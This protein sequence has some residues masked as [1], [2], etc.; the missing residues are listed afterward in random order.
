MN[1]DEAKSMFK[2]PSFARKEAYNFD[3]TNETF[4]VYQELNEIAE[5]L[6]RCRSKN[7]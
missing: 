1:I 3:S 5:E 6:E 7:F 2:V 4:A